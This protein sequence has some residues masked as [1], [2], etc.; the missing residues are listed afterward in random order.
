[1]LETLSALGAFLVVLTVGADRLHAQVAGADYEPPDGIGFRT[2]SV[3]SDGVRLHAE[4]FWPENRTGER[5]PTVVTAHGWG[6][7]ARILRNDAVDLARAGY[8]VVNF[9][10]KGWGES[11]GRLVAVEPLP[12]DRDRSTHTTLESRVREIRGIIDPFEQTSD[13]FNVIH[14]V[15]GEEMVDTARVGVRG[16]S[17][18]GGHVVYVAAFEPR[19]KALVSQVGATDIARGMPQMFEDSD[20]LATRRARGEVGYPDAFV[21]EHDLT[22]LPIHDKVARYSPN[23]VADRVDA[24]ALFI[25][26]EN[27]ELYTN[28]S[29]AFVAHERVQGPK[30]LVVIPEITHYAVYGEVREEVVGHAIDWFDEHLKE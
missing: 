14:W 5:L 3:T 22:G 17:F 18:S 26:A 12:E 28:E 30:R 21:R 23:A 29:Q 13:W 11:D 10:Y 20:A 25:V 19:I 9:D 24:A 6:G 8:L 1:M 15:M 7:T 4:L 2:A 27:E 16:T